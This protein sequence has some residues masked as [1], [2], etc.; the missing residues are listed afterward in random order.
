MDNK[1][2]DNYDKFHLFK[3]QKSKKKAFTLAEML[4]TLTLIGFL[5][6]ITLPSLIGDVSERA[7]E[8][9]KKA[10]YTRFSQVMPLMQNLAGFGILEGEYN[11]GYTNTTQ[12]TSAL[13]FVQEGLAKYLKIT[14]ICS[15]SHGTSN[16]NAAKELEKCGLPSK[17]TPIGGGN[18][19]N[20][21][22]ITTLGGLNP[23]FGNFAYTDENGNT[24]NYSAEYGRRVYNT[25][26]VAFETINGERVLVYYRP[27]CMKKQQGSNVHTQDEM[28]AN[29]I[30]DLNGKKGPNMVGKDI[31]VITALYPK[32][33][34]VVSPLPY[35]ISTE[36]VSFENAYDKCQEIADGSVVPSLEDGMSM[37]YNQK[38]FS[39][40][41][42]QSINY[43]TSTNRSLN[44]PWRIN[45]NTGYRYAVGNFNNSLQVWCTKRM[46]E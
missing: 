29:F 34:V 3:A 38:L 25:D 31:G 14:H 13:T 22:D 1:L 12:D 23:T 42:N 26:A 32:N 10:I 5:A 27:N 45:T 46:F 30:Y 37:Y 20:L 2:T 17:I 8:T 35:A 4:L 28:C 7:W 39:L 40:S 33:T 36:S 19:I 15:F 9:Q 6:S 44:N 11:N 18:P 41:P 43:W 16:A 21:S 24:T